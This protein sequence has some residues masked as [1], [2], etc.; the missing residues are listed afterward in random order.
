[1]FKLFVNIFVSIKKVN[2]R[3]KRNALKDGV[4]LRNT[5]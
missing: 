3:H 4:D 2:K 5:A 1:V